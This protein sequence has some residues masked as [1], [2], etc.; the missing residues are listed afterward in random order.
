MTYKQIL[1]KQI[2]E[3]EEK[4]QNSEGEKSELIKQLK[5]LQLSEFEEDERTNGTQQLLK[6]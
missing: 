4:I 6:G 1:Q 5:K 3:L 2:R